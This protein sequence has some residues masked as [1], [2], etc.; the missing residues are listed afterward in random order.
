MT[1]SKGELVQVIGV[2]LNF[3]YYYVRKL[4]NANSE[5]W[6]P[7][8]VL[9]YPIPI[10]PNIN[11]VNVMTTPMN[12]VV[13]LDAGNNGNSNNAGQ[14][15]KPWSFRFR[16]KPSFSRR[17]TEKG[18]NSSNN[19]SNGNGNMSCFT[20]DLVG[21]IDE[22]LPTFPVELQSARYH[23][24]ERVVLQC[25]V[26]TNSS[27]PV[28]VE[29]KDA[30]GHAIRNS[31]RHDV[32]FNEE[33]GIASL[34][35]HECRV[36]D[37]GRLTCVA[38]ND[39]G[40]NSTSCVLTVVGMHGMICDDRCIFYSTILTNVLFLLSHTTNPSISPCHLLCG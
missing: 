40:S 30:F 7:A 32:T 11:S 14:T 21:L 19:A 35:I 39:A 31:H 33:D 2:N 23:S 17:S 22:F 36:S 15:K 16:M 28:I 24:A 8:M 20:E 25:Q 27:D 13:S 1:V 4:N 10:P 29:W 34:I 6:A 9:Q 18:L 26:Q 12:T 5:G 38:T 37:S 3:S